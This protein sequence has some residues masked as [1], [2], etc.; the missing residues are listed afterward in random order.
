M[1]SSGLKGFDMRPSGIFDERY[2]QDIAVIRTKAHWGILFVGLG[3]LVLLALGRYPAL[4][5]Y[6]KSYW[7]SHCSRSRPQYPD[8]I[9]RPDFHR[10][11]RFYGGRCLHCRH[12]GHSGRMAFLGNHSNVRTVRGCCGDDIRVPFT[13]G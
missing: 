13:A 6:N 2:E 3:L 8:R 1:A 7:H 9:Y 5:F 11:G 4:S 12:S 10:A